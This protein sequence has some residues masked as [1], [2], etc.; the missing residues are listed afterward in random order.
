MKQQENIL[1]VSLEIIFN[2]KI[3]VRKHKT[4]ATFNLISSILISIQNEPF[5][6]SDNKKYSIIYTTDKCI[7]IDKIVSDN[8]GFCLT[9]VL[10]GE[11][12]S[13]SSIP[14]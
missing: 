1:S 6:I 9:L 5:C 12:N 10:S 11:F 3:A 13:W 8:E 4:V 14:L 7:T 2:E